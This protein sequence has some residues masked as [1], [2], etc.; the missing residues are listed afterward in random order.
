MI[1]KLIN[2]GRFK[3]KKRVEIDFKLLIIFAMSRYFCNLQSLP[4]DLWSLTEN[5][6]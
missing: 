3:H 2:Y 4:I 5:L 1:F 6:G